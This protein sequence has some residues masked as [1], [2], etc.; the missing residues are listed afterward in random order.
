M[1]DSERPTTSTTEAAQLLGVSKTTITR[2][3]KRGDLEAYKLTTGA[4]SPLRIYQDSVEALIQ[5]RQQQ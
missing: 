2:L 3:V 1:P 5:R 4:T